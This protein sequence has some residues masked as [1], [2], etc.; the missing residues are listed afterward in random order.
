MSYPM[1][2]MTEFSFA[3]RNA[4]ENWDMLNLMKI[5][6]GNPKSDNPNLLQHRFVLPHEIYKLYIKTSV[7]ESFSIPSFKFATGKM[8]SAETT[9][10]LLNF[11]EHGRGEILKFIDEFIEMLKRFEET[12][13]F[14]CLK[15]G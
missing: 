7:P 15:F 13:F 14:S 1:R 12:S 10:C 3:E 11:I 6:K 4:E 9:Q 2:D 5:S 8:T